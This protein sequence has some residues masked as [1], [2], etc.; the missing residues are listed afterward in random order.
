MK[1]KFIAA[2][3]IV[4]AIFLFM[5]GGA[6]HSGVPM[7]VQGLYEF[8]DGA[9]VTQAV[10]A[11]GQRG[12]GIYFT[13]EGLWASVGFRPDMSDKTQDLAPYFV[14][15]IITDLAVAFLLSLLI[16][17][18]KCSGMMERAGV[19]AMVA[20][21]AG[22]ENQVSDWNW[23]GFSA[24]FSVFEFIDIVGAWFVLGLILST[25]KNKL[26]PSA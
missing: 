9:A 19:L 13:K 8:Q 15:E 2:G 12:N 20:V 7:D 6:L 23:Y 14:V 21:A 17:A 26:A 11:N 10:K 1:G 18:I 16:L 3:T 25:L 24:R 4:G 5:W 22:F